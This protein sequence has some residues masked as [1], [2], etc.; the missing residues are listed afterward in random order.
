MGCGPGWAADREAEEERSRLERECTDIKDD[1]DFFTHRETVQALL[2][3][4]YNSQQ[5][6]Y[7]H[8]LA[9]QLRTSLRLK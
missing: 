1:L 7:V 4:L 8:S 2:K 9:E 3:E 5:T 6:R